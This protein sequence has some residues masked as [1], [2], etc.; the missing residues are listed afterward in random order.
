MKPMD[1]IKAENLLQTRACYGCYRNFLENFFPV[2]FFHL[3]TLSIFIACS[4]DTNCKRRSM[5]VERKKM[6]ILYSMHVGSYTLE[7]CKHNKNLNNY[8][9]LVKVF[10]MYNKKYSNKL[11]VKFLLEY[12]Q[13][14]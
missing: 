1:S 5:E 9:F 8:F 6:L 2:T 14:N 13:Q 4:L 3:V 12:K 11:L 7:Y 10:S